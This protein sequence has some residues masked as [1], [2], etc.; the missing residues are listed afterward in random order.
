MLFELFHKESGAGGER[1][2]GINACLD[3]DLCGLT[4]IM[5]LAR[6]EEASRR[7]Q[8]KIIKLVGLLPSF[9]GMTVFLRVGGR[10]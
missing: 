10:C 9:A 4:A 1:R 8:V 5:L 7:R 2:W 3:N 6:K